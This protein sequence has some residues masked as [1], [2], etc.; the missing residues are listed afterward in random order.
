MDELL[1]PPDTCRERIADDIRAQL[2]ALKAAGAAAFDPVGVHVIESLLRRSAS[3]QGAAL[4]DVQARLQHRLQQLQARFEQARSQA[5]ATAKAL[6]E[7]SPEHNDT[8]VRL[9]R[10][11]DF[12]AIDRLAQQHAR[13][14]THSPLKALLQT[15]TSH[16]P[17]LDASADPVTFDEVLRKQELQAQ[18]GNGLVSLNSHLKSRLN[19]DELRSTRQF[20]DLWAKRTI[21][22]AIA[23]AL[24]EAPEN[25]GPLNAHQLVIRALNTMGEISP[26]YLNRFVSYVHT[27]IWLEQAAT[28]FAPPDIKAGEGKA[29]P[30]P[31]RG[32]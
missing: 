25:A 19:T 11:G 21:D 32:A 1:V 18:Q 22:R 28:R 15:L 6:R 23:R 27:L 7:Q 13:Q 20:R 3:L 4:A 24:D 30:R 14:Q 5:K 12:R 8:L 2:A 9:F 26:D 10:A 31:R 29:R 16:D 17:L